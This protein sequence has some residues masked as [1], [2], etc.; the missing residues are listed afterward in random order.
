MWFVDYLYPL[1]T[2]WGVQMLIF[3]LWDLLSQ[4]LWE[5]LG[6]LSTLPPVPF[7]HAEVYVSLGEVLRRYEN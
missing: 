5:W 1:L 3:G 2:H 6:I 4:N 7:M